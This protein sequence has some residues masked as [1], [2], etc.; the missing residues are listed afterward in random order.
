MNR[1]ENRLVEIGRIG[2]VHG[3]DGTVR[4][5]ASVEAE[6][7]IQPEE[8]LYLRDRRGDFVPVRVES[9]RIEEKRNR[10]LFFVKFD[11]IASRTDAESFLE[12]GVYSDRTVMRSS[13]VSETAQRILGYQVLDDSGVVGQVSSVM[14]NP[15]H[16]I[17]EIRSTE[18]K[19]TSFFLVP[20]VD[21]YVE[22]VDDQK[23]RVYCSG[24]ESLKNL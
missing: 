17:I 22:I 10:R 7:V 13:I 19:N 3:L 21:A 24:I 18:E 14:E 1:T 23:Q 9:V 2:N 15:A 12:T 16:P 5:I 11:R 6:G 20:W 4:V 8:L